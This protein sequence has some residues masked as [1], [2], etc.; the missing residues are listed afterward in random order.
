M[1]KRALFIEHDHVS[2]G[3]PIWEQFKK[4]GYEIVRFPI[5]DESNF[6]KPNVK[7]QWPDVL[8]FDVVVPMG[9]PWGAW[10][11]A[12][13][14]NWLLPEIELMKSVHNAGIPILGI[15]FG[16][17]L[18][19][20]VLGGSVAR[21]PKAELGWYEITSDDSS[22]IPSGPWFQYH[23]DRWKTPSCATEIARTPIASQAFICGR[24]LGLQFHPEIDAAV[25][26]LWLEM[27]GGCVEVENEGI[28]VELL[29]AETKEHQPRSNQRAYDLVD[30]FLD[31]I[32]V[33]PVVRV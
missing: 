8:K 10:E 25:L 1:K 23:W 17:Q 2:E 6:N 4:R 11:D 22:L 3:G 15:C 14:G 29:R 30:Q 18:M 13:I 7:V 26:D 27:E 28:S 19:A 9:A 12:R 31:R 20:R 16:G 21:A 32:A 5:V 33:A 24:T